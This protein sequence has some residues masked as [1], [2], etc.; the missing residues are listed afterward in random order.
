MSNLNE[1]EIAKILDDQEEKCEDIAIDCFVIDNCIEWSNL[2]Q[3]LSEKEVALYEWKEIYNVKSEEIISN[4][5]FKELYG[6]N[7]DKVRKDHVKRELSDWDKTIKELEFSIDYL[8]R[9]LSFLKQ[10]VNTKT[11]LIGVKNNEK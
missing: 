5:D 8:K 6:K 4:T 1:A 11:A 7:N 10:L 3:E 9:R 2:I